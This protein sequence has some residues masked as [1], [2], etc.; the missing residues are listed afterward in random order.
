MNTGQQKTAVFAGSFDPLTKGHESIILRALPLFDEIHVMI[1]INSQKSGMFCL[2]KRIEWIE[3]TFKKYP[4]IKAVSYKGLTIDYCRQVG[5]SYILRG[6]RSTT[7]FQ[8]EQNIARINQTIDPEIETLFMLTLTEDIPI[9]SSAVRE[10][11]MF[12]GDVSKFVPTAIVR[13]IQDAKNSI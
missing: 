1:G 7:D 5:A 2:E 10:I 11:L 8:Y 13:S 6:V 12:G 9:S 3:T 4:Q